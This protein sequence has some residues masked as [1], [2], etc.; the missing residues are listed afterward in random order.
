MSPDPVREQI[1]NDQPDPSGHA[2][3]KDGDVAEQ[4]PVS[5]TLT[6]PGTGLSSGQETATLSSWR[7]VAPGTRTRST[8]LVT[9]C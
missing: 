2:R 9:A 5:D 1:G 3:T 7:K 4:R 8:K 6:T